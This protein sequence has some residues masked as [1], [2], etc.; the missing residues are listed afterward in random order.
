MY[1]YGERGDQFHAAASCMPHVLV[2]INNTNEGRLSRLDDTPS[3]IRSNIAEPPCSM[4]I[5]TGSRQVPGGRSR[6]YSPLSGQKSPYP[7]EIFCCPSP[8]FAPTSTPH[9]MQN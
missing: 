3:I 6:V 4:T 5:P 1:T 8:A 9:Q 7:H 2:F